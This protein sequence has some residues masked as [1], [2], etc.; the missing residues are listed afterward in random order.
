MRLEH[1][2]TLRPVCP[3]CRGN[4]GVAHPVRLW[5]VFAEADGHIIEALLECPNPACRREY[6]V[7]DGIPML[8][9]SL[10]QHVEHNALGLLCRDDLGPE[11]ESILGDCA[12]PNSSFDVMRQHISHYASDHY[13][14]L[15]EGLPG[16]ER[17]AAGGVLRM[18]EAGLGLVGE[19]PPG[20]VL[21]MGCSVGRTSFEL[22]TGTDDLVLG[23]DL[24]F[25]M[26]RVASRV[27]RSG[28]V[29]YGRRRVG[30][31]YDRRDYAVDLANERVDFWQCDALALPFAG[32][33]FGLVTSLNLLDCLSSPMAHLQNFSELLAAHGRV[34]LGTPYDWSPAA[35]QLGG[36]IG[37]H[38]QR[39]PAGGS[40]EMLL[41]WILEG[42]EGF[43]GV[44]LS[45][46]ADDPQ[47]PWAVR[48]HARSTAHYRSH[49]MV[50][51]HQATVPG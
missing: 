23:V 43:P 8:V 41:R 16:E 33:P 50:L 46:V 1:F 18:L 17:A 4:D 9:A 21:D 48:L 29:R 31:V 15:D 47:V 11:V 44:G 49:L 12:G 45:V 6:P 24:N 36:W 5:K 38:S 34:I 26:L 39:G 32:Q 35:T 28:R 3:T 13:G 27:L 10:R 25:S 22:A 37:G 42:K 20:P 30:I 51:A 14:D 7:I 40:S 19:R 2:E